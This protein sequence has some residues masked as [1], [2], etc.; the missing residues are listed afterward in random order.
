MDHYSDSYNFGYFNSSTD[1]SS[2]DDT[3]IIIVDSGDGT[4]DTESILSY[5]NED[6]YNTDDSIED[7]YNTDDGIEY[8]SIHNN[9]SQHFY[10]DKEDG[11]YYL[12]IY[13]VYSTQNNDPQ[14]LLSSSVSAQTF[15]N[16]SYDNINNYLYYYGLV[17][18]IP[19]HQVQIMQVNIL[20]DDTCTV[21]IKTYWLRIIQ[22]RWKKIYTLRIK[23]ARCRAMPQ[24]QQYIQ[25]H[26]CYPRHLIHMPSIQ[27]M[28]IPV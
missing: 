19:N 13:N 23:I 21:I 17:R 27:G 1:D 9:D 25:I 5:G 14:L 24:N 7:D 11:K 8:D 18:R 16:Y 6:D 26:G 22:R 15:F 3:S 28:M 4:T 12:G 20:N 2:T 10:S